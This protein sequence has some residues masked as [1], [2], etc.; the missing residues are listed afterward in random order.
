MDVQASLKKVRM[1]KCISVVE[2]QYIKLA[3]EASR[4]FIY[5]ADVMY[6]PGRSEVAIF[7][8][9][10][11][12]QAPSEVLDKARDAIEKAIIGEVHICDGCGDRP[13]T[14]LHKANEASQEI[15]LCSS[16]SLSLRIE[17]SCR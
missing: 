17:R 15:Y 11:Y 5:S 16:C 9:V 8:N 3:L 2:F 10:P 6:L 13:A 12:D 1:I 4:K 14:K 7:G